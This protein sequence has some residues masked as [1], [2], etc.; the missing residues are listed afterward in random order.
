MLE[1][2]EKRI[3]FVLPLFKEGGAEKTV[4][5]IMAG[6]AQQGYEVHLIILKDKVSLAYPPGVSGYVLE[7]PRMKKL[8]E[9]F[10]KKI[11]AHRLKKVVNTINPAMIFTSLPRA[12]KIV[13]R[14]LAKE[15]H[16]YYIFH[17]TP[18]PSLSHKQFSRKIAIQRYQRMYHGK[19][20]ITLSAGI[21]EDLI[22]TLGI[23]AKSIDVINNP[24]DI[25]AIKTMAEEKVDDLPNGDFLLCVSHFYKRKRHDQRV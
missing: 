4:S 25:E 17:N 8:P 13:S 9:F 11:Y 24:F 23:E 3:V 15:K 14:A 20:L 5:A 10:Q 6:L 19:Q 1:E 12:H 16:L 2:K 18:S 21:K 7:T 22:H